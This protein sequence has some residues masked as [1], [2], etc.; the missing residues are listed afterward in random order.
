MYSSRHILRRNFTTVTLNRNTNQ[1]YDLGKYAVDFIKNGKPSEKVVNRLK[2]FHTDSVLCGLAA[3]SLKMGSSS[4]FKN[5]AFQYMKRGGMQN[6]RA[7]LGYS[8]VFGS[9]EIAVVEKSIM[10]NISAVSELDA[11]GTIFGY[12]KN[13]P[14]HQTGEVSHNDFYPVVVGAAQQNTGITGENLAK[15]MILLDEIRGR[16]CEAYSL[17]K[18]NIDPVLNGAI[19]S[20]ITYGALNGATPEHIENAI[21]IMIAHHLPYRMIRD[22][23]QLTDSRSASAAMTT[24]SA[25]SAIKRAMNGFSGPR[26]VFRNPRSIFGGL[27]ATESESPFDLMLMKEGS[28]FSIMSHHFKLGLYVYHAAGAIEGVI[29]LLKENQF[30]EHNNPDCIESI[31]ILGYQ[32]AVDVIGGDSKKNPTN[33]HAAVSSMYYI[34]KKFYST[35][36]P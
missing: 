3:L 27:G 18:C 8:K 2:L 25:I 13:L 20:A 4:L 32:A 12:N 1:A 23:K 30:I 5:E 6:P 7:K 33:R 24:E 36:F 17:K 22:S 15:G 28:N 9:N 26:D 16:L 11:T 34:G 21:G 29:K 19:A 35:L 10:A 14:G 31:K